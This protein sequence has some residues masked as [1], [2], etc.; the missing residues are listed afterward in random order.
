MRRPVSLFLL[1]IATMAIAVWFADRP[2]TAVIVWQGYRIETSVGVLLLGVL[3]VALVVAAVYGLWRRVIN[4]PRVVSRWRREGRRRRG[5][6]ALTQGLVA[7]AAGDADA[8]R[9]Q[10]RRA[11]HLLGDPP[12][13][14]LLSAQAAQLSGDEA[15]AKAQFTAMLERPETAFLGL[16]GLLLQALRE[17]DHAQ[18]RELARRAQA[19]RP[20]TPWVLTTLF[21]LETQAG[22]WRAALETVERLQRASVIAPVPAA[23]RKAAVLIELSR[24]AQAERRERD[25]VV[26][27]ERAHR[28]DPNH[29]AAVL[30]LAQR[31]ATTDRHR[32]AIQL[33]EREWPRHPLPDL[34]ASYRAARRPVT[35]AQ[36]LQQAQRLAG[37]APDHVESHVTLATAALDAG[38][39]GEARRHAE[40]AI[41]AGAAD[42]PARLCRLMARIEEAESGDPAALRRWLDRAASAPPDAAWVCEGCGAARADW[43]ARCARCGAFDR[44]V[45][46]AP[47]RALPLIVAPTIEGESRSPRD[48]DRPPEQVAISLPNRTSSSQ[49]E[50]ALLDKDGARAG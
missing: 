8:A 36:W 17:G 30:W 28:A 15:T 14:M 5:Y 22:D 11:D 31:Y 9:R 19:L 18:A 25:A 48:G 2:G 42:A 35:A 39:W 24:A 29:A 3:A 44:F 49:A 37:L 41:A 1:L 45:W 47:D 23:Q 21:D 12:L 7:V 32:A 10:A 40:A 43:Q 50:A 46:R 4:S 33:I 26:Y 6:L 13:T 20:R 27:A 16:R 38:L 34:V